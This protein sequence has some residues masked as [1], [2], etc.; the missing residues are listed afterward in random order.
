MIT[1]FCLFIC[2]LSVAGDEHSRNF[3]TVHAMTPGHVEYCLLLVD[4]RSVCL[5]G[6]NSTCWRYLMSAALDVITYALY[7]MCLV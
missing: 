4:F 7:T 2:T 1:C 6:L 3:G 5:G